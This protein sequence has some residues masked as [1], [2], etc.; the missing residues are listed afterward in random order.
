MKFVHTMLY[1]SLIAALTAGANSRRDDF[2]GYQKGSDGSPNW[3]ATS[4]GWEVRD[5]KYVASDVY[6]EFSIDDTLPMGRN[7]Q[8]EATVSFM[9]EQFVKVNLAQWNVIDKVTDETLVRAQS[10]W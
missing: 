2:D 4:I 3:H 9:I 8:V 1:F 5:G 7:V 10:Q 6:R